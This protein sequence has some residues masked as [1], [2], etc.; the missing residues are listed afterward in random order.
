MLTP[1]PKPPPEANKL[2]SFSF[3]GIEQ[4][5]QQGGAIPIVYGKCFVGSAVLSSGIDTF[6]G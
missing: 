6:D 3:S 2:K 5:T 1:V 4:T